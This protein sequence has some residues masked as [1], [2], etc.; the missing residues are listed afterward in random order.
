M[1]E[2]LSYSSAGATWRSRPEVEA[3]AEPEIA[4]T[5]SDDA[6]RAEFE[7]AAQRQP[8]YRNAVEVVD[9]SRLSFSSAGATRRR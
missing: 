7:A 5:E 6:I 3:Q 1:T 4:T 2:L 9:E 8:N